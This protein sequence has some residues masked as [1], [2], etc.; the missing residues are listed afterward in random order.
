MVEIKEGKKLFQSIEAE[1]ILENYANHDH[2]P[3]QTS[4]IIAWDSRNKSGLIK[5][6]N[7]WQYQWNYL[8]NILDVILLKYL[9]DLEVKTK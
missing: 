3:E 2:V 4:L 6:A 5:K 1:Y 7:E 8:D 9:P